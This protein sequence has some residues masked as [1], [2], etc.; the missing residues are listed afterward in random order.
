MR[1]ID[2]TLEQEQSE[3]MM[4]S[5]LITLDSNEIPK[6]GKLYWKLVKAYEKAGWD[7]AVNREWT[8]NQYELSFVARDSLRRPVRYAYKKDNPLLL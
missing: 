8:G 2:Q 7:I 5:F 1:E 3:R 6:G 4:D